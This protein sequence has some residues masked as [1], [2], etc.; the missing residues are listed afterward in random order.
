VVKPTDIAHLITL[1]APA[2]SPDGRTAV[3]AATRPDLDEN[4]YRGQLWTVP[5]DRS[6]PPRRLTNG[7]RDSAPRF[8]PDGRWL[9]FV[10]AEPE[11]K[12][13]LYVLPAEGGEARRLTDLPGGAGAPEWSPDSAAIAFTARVPEPGRYGQD[14]K[15]TPDK[16]PP[17]RITGL[18]YRLDDVGFLI[19]Q[20]EHV[21][22]VE[23]GDEADHPAPRQITDGDYEDADVAWSSDGAWLTFVSARHE[24]REHDEVRDVFVI[25]PDGTQLRRLSDES[26]G[27]GRPVFTP[28]G[29]TVLAVAED[30]GPE[31]KYWFAANRGLFAISLDRPGRPRRLTDEETY[32]LEF[33]R[34]VIDG[35]QALVQTENRGAVDLLSVPL[36][37]GP[38]AVLCGGHRQITGVAVAGGTTVVTFTDPGTPGELAVL[39]DGELRV[40]TDFAARLREN[41]PPRPMAEFTASAPDGYPVHGFLVVPDGDGPHPVLLMIHG[42]PFT[43]YGW[44]PF[45]EAQVYAGAGYA[46]VYG[47]P[48][49]SSGYGQAH[50]AY[51]RGDV[52]ARSAVGLFALLDAALARPDLDGNRVGVLGGSH[53]GYM[54]S[55][56]VGHS[57][58]FRAAVSERAVN[59]I[60][61]FIGSS[62]I[63][64]GF[65]SDLY[66]ADD[67]DEL[68]R[69]SPL[70]YAD[71]ISTPLLIVHSEED[72]RCPLEQAQRLYV[73][74]RNRDATVE[75]L[76]MPGEGHEMSR[77]GL[78]SHRVARFDAILD[79]F[80]RYLR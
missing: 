9:A 29:S 72:W 68:R 46:V 75:M 63:G 42:G 33:E 71:A 4:E 79:W 76:L 48:R 64:W 30:P 53:G 25:R 80:E 23:L 21:F 3:V 59:A 77:S 69:Q 36:D 38:P 14:K 66:T 8:S 22:V 12:P 74:L 55:W 6:G 78:P 27:L 62:D 70:T 10:R 58:R 57:D 60:D 51:I 50:G 24:R 17:R 44:T 2:L 32:Q 54:T 35:D 39:R 19:D 18:Q 13:Q 37:G 67:P 31:R 26:L 61:S 43:Q 45:D 1:G 65:V 15:V 11:G 28:D 73:A 56:L 49:G 34:P 16:E 5:T 41:S 7:P 52:G 47:N 40:L 20:R